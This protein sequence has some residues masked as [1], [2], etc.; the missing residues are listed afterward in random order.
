MVAKL[1]KAVIY[2][3]ELPS[4]KSYDPLLSGL[5]RSRDQLNLLY[6]ICWRPMKT[7]LDKIVTC[8]KSLKLLKSYDIILYLYFHKTYIQ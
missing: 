3:Y 2:R 6:S 1:V 5:V 4:I 7:K 8:R